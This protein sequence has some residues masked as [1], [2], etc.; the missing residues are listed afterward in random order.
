VGTTKDEAYEQLQQL[1]RLDEL[2]GVS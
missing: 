2:S 1:A